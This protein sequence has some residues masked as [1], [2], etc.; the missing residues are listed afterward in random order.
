MTD[1]P[2]HTGPWTEWRAAMVG[3]RMHHG[4]IL[5]GKSGLGKHEFAVAAARALVA[6]DGVSQPAGEHPDIITLTYG[7]KDDKAERAAADGKDYERAR[8]IRVKQIRAMQKRLNT[9]PTLGDRRVVIINPADDMETGASN[10]LLKSLEE[11]PQGTFFMLVT[12]RPARLLP[13]IRSRCRVLRFPPL[14]DAQLEAMLDAAEEAAG[15]DIEAAIR[16]AQGS[17][18]AAL[19]FADQCLAPIADAITA[20]ITGCDT[21]MKPRADLATMIGPRADRERLQAVMELAQ[22]IV[23]EHARTCQ[24]DAHRAALIEA[25]AQLVT[26][27]AQAPHHNFDTGLLTLE[28]GTLLTRAAPASA[29]AHG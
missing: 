17:Y 13:T 27:A 3:S 4:W 15:D 28:I 5:A 8:S 9:R 7:P 10:A 24:D 20:M 18:G 19:R 23:A 11:P 29:P 16:A 14:S 2:N 21:T 26:L 22:A 1:W 25:H 12:H 6:E